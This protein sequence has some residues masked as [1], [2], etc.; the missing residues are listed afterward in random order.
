[1]I[2]AIPLPPPYVAAMATIGGSGPTSG[3]FDGWEDVVNL[4]DQLNL[5][6]DEGKVTAFSNNEDCVPT[7]VKS[8]VIGKSFRHQPSISLLSATR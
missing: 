7:V 4:L 1:M 5:T 6:V 8:A 3:S 2:G